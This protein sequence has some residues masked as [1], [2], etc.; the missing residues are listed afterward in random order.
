MQ[1]IEPTP[2]S[3]HALR[4]GTSK[5]PRR[6]PLRAGVLEDDHAI[7]KLYCEALQQEDVTAIP[8]ENAFEMTVAARA[9]MVDIALIDLGLG[10]EDG[11]Q[12]IR[13]LRVFSGLPILI[14]SGRTAPETICEGLDCGADDFLRKPFNFAELRAR[15]RNLA[16]RARATPAR[17]EAGFA[18]KPV[19]IDGVR[20]DLAIGVAEKFNQVCHFT[21]RES[22]ILQ[23][24]LKTPGQAVSRD[25]ISRAIFG[26]GWDP[27]NRMLDVHVS[28][29]RTKLEAIG[30][31][32]RIIR[33]RR[34]LGYII[35]VNTESRAQR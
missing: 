31:S 14:V 4:S 29:I 8:F 30:A 9:N 10:S 11:L 21:D 17:A 28:N 23:C 15:I 3:K 34:N 35:N 32:P 6:L 1:I 27:T 20:F 26:E 18:V 24:M 5:S 16:R 22:H 19:V 2:A 12:I 13:E 33:T 7:R 25:T